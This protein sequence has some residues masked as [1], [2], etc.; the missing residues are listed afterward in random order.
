[1][2]AKQIQVAN[3]A[4]REI[5]RFADDTVLWMKHCTGQEADPWQALFIHEIESHP[6]T[7]IVEPPRFGK[8]WSM[9]AVDCKE[10]F[11]MPKESLMIFGPK[12][13]Q[14]NNALAEHL[15]W[16]EG[17]EILKNY[18]A[19]K[20]GK[21]QISETKYQLLNGSR[22]K[23]FGIWS[24]FD[25]EEGS[26]IRG[27]EFDDIDIDRWRDRVL[28]RGGRKNR[29]GSPTRYR[30]SGTIQR[31]NGNIYNYVNNAK[32]GSI[33]FKVCTIF[34]IYHGLEFGIYDENA[35]NLIKQDMTDEEWLRIYMMIFT[36][37]RNFIWESYLRDCIEYGLKINWVGVPFDRQR[38]FVPHGTVY[39]GL[40]CGHAGQKKQS[41]VYSL[42]IFEVIGEKVAWLNGF[43]WDPTTDP[44]L[45]KKEIADI[46]EYYHIRAGYADA[47][48]A[49]L[50]AEINDYLFE[51]RLTNIDR[52]KY[53][54][55]KPGAW[56]EWALAPKWN[57]GQFKYLAALELKK[58]IEQRNL[59]LPYFDRK[60]DRHIAQMWRRL[61]RTLTNVRQV[62]TK[63]SYPRLEAINIRIGDD[64]FDAACMALQCANDRQIM[65]PD[66]SRVEAAGSEL[67]TAQ[68][69][70]SALEKLR[71]MGDNSTFEDF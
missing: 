56:N 54:E 8:T 23:T 37:A 42:Q 65:R 69:V 17:S 39:C 60:D 2:K 1:M 62:E 46:W 21:R 24:Q 7:I 29:S 47:L 50:V 11:T 3:R 31:S 14:A 10:L 4:E 48:Q 15:E 45:L 25:S 59:V 70:D 38:P 12:Q 13:E 51:R 40:D 58:K 18:I 68:L 27:E 52:A 9:E 67:T 19:V 36:E 41:S 71:R 32:N 30:L 5:M 44:K 28:A 57:T 6:N 33:D 66:F 63:G 43:E 26:I 34:N 16:I 35:I 49:A 53:P 22:A 20:R 55:N 64:A 61:T